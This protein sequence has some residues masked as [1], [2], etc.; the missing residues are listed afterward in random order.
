MVYFMVSNYSVLN[1]TISYRGYFL[2]V[3]DLDIMENKVAEFKDKNIKLV[4]DIENDA[5][6]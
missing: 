3:I 5:L 1:I 6:I 4:V 2:S